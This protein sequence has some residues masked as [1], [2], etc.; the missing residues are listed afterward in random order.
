MMLP[1]RKKTTAEAKIEAR[2]A[3]IKNRREAVSNKRNKQDISKSKNDRKPNG[4]YK[5]LPGGRKPIGPAFAGKGK[6]KNPPKQG[7]KV[8]HKQRKG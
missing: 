7:G 8:T 5:P 4:P 1:K 2:K 6:L 3:W